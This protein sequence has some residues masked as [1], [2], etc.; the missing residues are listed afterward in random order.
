MQELGCFEV[1]VPN[2]HD[3]K[4]RIIRRIRR[5]QEARTGKIAASFRKKRVMRTVT[6]DRVHNGIS[7]VLE[8]KMHEKDICTNVGDELRFLHC[9]RDLT[10]N[11]TGQFK[12]DSQGERRW[13]GLRSS[14]GMGKTIY[15][16]KT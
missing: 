8:R 14:G 15:G 1:E 2:D 6:L 5:H 3:G 7:V 9:C 12:E 16:K 11:R 4:L 13:H 10:S